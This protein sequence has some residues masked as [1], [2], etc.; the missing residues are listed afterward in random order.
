MTALRFGGDGLG[1]AIGDSAPYTGLVAD[2]YSSA[3]TRDN[4]RC[5]YLTTG[6]LVSSCLYQNG[7]CPASEPASCQP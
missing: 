5:I 6:T 7:A 4:H 1:S 2:V 3:I